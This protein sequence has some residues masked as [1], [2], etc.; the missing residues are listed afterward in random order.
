MVRQFDTSKYEEEPDNR[1]G[2]IQ[3]LEKQLEVIKFK[4]GSLLQE[5]ERLQRKLRKS[6][7]IKIQS[8]EQGSEN[9]LL[10]Q[11]IHEQFDIIASLK[12]AESQ[13]TSLREDGQKHC[14]LR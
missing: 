3:N 1:S 8:K 4:T 9:D 13:I 12:S 7:F 2:I 5:N 6:T 11:Q 14:R 10:R